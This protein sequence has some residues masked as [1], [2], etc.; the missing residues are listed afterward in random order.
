MDLEKGTGEKY[1][2]CAYINTKYE[3]VELIDQ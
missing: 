1:A 3:C 2:V